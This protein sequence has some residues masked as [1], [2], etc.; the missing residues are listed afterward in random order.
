MLIISLSHNTKMKIKILSLSFLLF[1]FSCKDKK[2]E[3]ETP[4]PATSTTGNTP[5]PDINN[6]F[7]YGVLKKV[8][9][10]WNGPVTSTTP[11]GGYP[12]WIVD[13]RPIS[14]NQI[15]AKNE[16]DTLNDIHMSFF[17]ALYNN[18]YKVAFRNGGSFAGMKRVSYFLADSVSE[19]GAYSFYRFSEIIK[20]KKRAYTE[21]ILRADSLYIKSYTNKYN[22][23]SNST[24]HMT[25]SAKLQDTTS[26][27]AATANFT[28]PKKTSTKDFSNTFAGQT[29]AVY[30]NN[31]LEP[32]PESSQPYLGQTNAG[33]TFGPGYTPVSTKKVFLVITTQPLFSGVVFNPANLKFRS[34]YVILAANDNNYIFNYMHPGTYYYYAL[35]DNDGNNVFGSGDWISTANTTF[36]LGSQAS[37]N[38]STQ[39]NFTIP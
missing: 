34:R 24:P 20:G 39:I 27:Q 36:N 9:G 25:W 4:E 7:A 22:T 1:L 13:F 2:T 8:K 14:E 30:Y 32:Y 31:P 11:L 26:S 21:V 15:S 37:A 35:Y 29:E 18:E 38:T 5:T 10:I 6:T 16:L 19:I 28:F 17:I 12:E 3:E 33:Y 23:Q